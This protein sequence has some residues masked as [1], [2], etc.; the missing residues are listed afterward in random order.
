MRYLGPG[1]GQLKS[2]FYWDDDND[3]LVQR[4]QGDVTD[5]IDKNKAQQ[6]EWGGRF[7]DKEIYHKV[8]SIPNEIIH[9]WLVEEGFNPYQDMEHLIKKKLNDPNW[10][11]L[12]T[13]NV[14]I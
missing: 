7:G 2:D 3:C 9:Q 1:T 4:T 11:Y 8:A 5:A 10:K 13:K 6:N 12:K 14:I